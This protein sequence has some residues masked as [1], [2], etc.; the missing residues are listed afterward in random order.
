MYIAFIGPEPEM[1]LDKPTGLD[2]V[3]KICNDGPLLNGEE[4]RCTDVKEDDVK[5]DDL[6]NDDV[7]NDDVTTSS[8]S[9]EVTA[10]PTVLASVV[11]ED[12]KSEEK[13]DDSAAC[14]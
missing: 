7:K 10:R 3:Q 4:T 2:D 1:C 14:K 9:N 6:N 8:L 12:L 13:F 5:N 11:T